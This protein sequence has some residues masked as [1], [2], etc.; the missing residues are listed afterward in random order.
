L[1]VC[2]VRAQGARGLCG[3]GSTGRADFDFALINIQSRGRLRRAD[4]DALA[5]IAGDD[6]TGIAIRC[7]MVGE[8]GGCR[9]KDDKTQEDRNATLHKDSL[10]ESFGKTP[11]R[12]PSTGERGS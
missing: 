11:G 10:P 4:A 12:E 3:T 9:A 7:W 8:R 1:Q 2:F 5:L 6:L